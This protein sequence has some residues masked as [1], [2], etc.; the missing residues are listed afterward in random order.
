MRHL[1]FLLKAILISFVSLFKLI[2][3]QL[4]V[5]S[6]RDSFMNYILNQ[7][8]TFSWAAVA[9]R[10]FLHFFFFLLH[11]SKILRR[12]E[13]AAQLFQTREPICTYFWQHCRK[14]PLRLVNNKSMHM[15]NIFIWGKSSRLDNGLTISANLIFMTD[16]Q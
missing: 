10:K 9:Y 1:D 13:F 4:K 12:N 8:R 14:A 5:F 3:A 2:T 6:K 15:Q 7:P 11:L 16:I